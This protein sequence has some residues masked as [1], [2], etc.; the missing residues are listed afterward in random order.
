M[1]SLQLDQRRGI[2][3]YDPLEQVGV[4]DQGSPGRLRA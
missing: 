1:A 2:P 3:P 4:G